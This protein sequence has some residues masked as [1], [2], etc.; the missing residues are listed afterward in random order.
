MRMFEKL[1]DVCV[2]GLIA[3][4]TIWSGSVAAQ[5]P[6]ESEDQ[7]ARDLT[8]AQRPIFEIGR[9]HGLSFTEMEAWVEHRGHTYAIGEALHVMVR[10]HKEAYITVVDV[11][12]SGKVTVLYPNYFQ[13]SS[14]VRG[15]STL[16]IPHEG[17]AW[18]IKVGGPPG[19]DLI[20]VF[21]SQEPLSLPELDLLVRADAK[22]PMVSMGRSGEEVARDLIPQLKRDEGK[23]SRER[24]GV[25]NV[26]VRI[27][28]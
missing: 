12:T 17:A 28:R 16:E 8:V 14:R 13:H 24:Y 9:Q 21:A 15:G 19:V 2:A 18:Q 11:G 4:I 10:P 25:R 3:G 6:E 5:S 23:D 20:E 22:N 26:L 1:G 7:L 27:V